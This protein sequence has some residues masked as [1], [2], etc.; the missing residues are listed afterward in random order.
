MKQH[1]HKNNLLDILSHTVIY[2]SANGEKEEMYHLGIIYTVILSNPENLKTDADGED[3][4]GASWVKLSEFNKEDFSPFA[5][6][7]I[8]KHL[9]KKGRATNNI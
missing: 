9:Q 8:A 4:Q 3:S 1:K 6:Q 5:S 7:S 2:E